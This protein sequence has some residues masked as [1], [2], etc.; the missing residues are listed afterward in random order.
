[1]PK[2]RKRRSDSSKTNEKGAN[3]RGTNSEDGF[4]HSNGGK[5]K[6]P[7]DKATNPENDERR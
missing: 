3:E 2:G 4:D 6:K 1:M 5:Q 7:K